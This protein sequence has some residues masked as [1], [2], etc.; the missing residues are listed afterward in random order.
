MI[1][2]PGL[3]EKVTILQEKLKGSIFTIIQAEMLEIGLKKVSAR[4]PVNDATKQAFGVLH[5]GVSAYVAESIASIGGW[6]HINFETQ[7]CVGIEI[8]ASHL[9]AVDEGMVTATATPLRI[10][11]TIHVW[12]VECRDS[13]DE[14]VSISQCTLLVRMRKK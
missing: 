2:A 8:N 7:T 11:K 9:K 10:G 5:G 1:I 14:L 6:L 4:F 12:Q 3:E 13:Q